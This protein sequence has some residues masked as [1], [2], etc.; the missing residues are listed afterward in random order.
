MEEAQQ[1]L[2]EQQ[3]LIAI[4]EKKNKK[5]SHCV[6]MLEKYRDAVRNAESE[7]ERQLFHNLRA[8]VFIELKDIRDV[9]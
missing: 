3:V 1:Q 7:D 6:L 8:S 4:Q 5:E 2:I 9:V